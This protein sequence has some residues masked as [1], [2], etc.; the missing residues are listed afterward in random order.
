MRVSV[1]MNRCHRTGA[2]GSSDDCISG[3]EYLFELPRYAQ[4]GEPR[5][6]S[7]C[8][9][10]VN[11]LRAGVI[12]LSI[13]IDNGVPLARKVRVVTTFWQRH[14]PFGR[15]SLS[16]DQGLLLSPAGSIHSFGMPGAM[17]VVCLDQAWQVLA[18]RAC[19]PPARWLPAPRATC[20]VLLL[21]AGRCAL[22]GLEPGMTVYRDATDKAPLPFATTILR[23]SLSS[24]EPET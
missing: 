13:R 9:H 4:C 23:R 22:T 7:K 5:R 8:R 3:N 17:D 2:A 21:A 15:A 1:T 20:A 16:A 19:L 6:V 24:T 12:V 18:C 11:Q 10:T 14:G